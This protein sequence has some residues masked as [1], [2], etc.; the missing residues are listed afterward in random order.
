MNLPEVIRK[1]LEQDYSEGHLVPGQAIDEKALALRFK[2]SRTPVREAL[3]LLS[4]NGLIDIQPRAGTFVRKLK[5]S[6]LVAMMEALGELEAVLARLATQ[7]IDAQKREEL[8][9]CLQQTQQAADNNAVTS[10]IETNARLHEV[11]YR[12]SGNPYLV[13][14]AKLVRLRISGYRRQ[15]LAAPGRLAQSQQEHRLVV[16]AILTGHANEAYELMR[17]HI[18]AGGQAF[19]DLILTNEF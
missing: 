13:T 14:Q 5:A 9:T 6:E 3:L 18:S 15:L 7:R 19:A 1:Q 16:E 12:A 10:Y 2:T 4:A 8:M 17:A 11:I